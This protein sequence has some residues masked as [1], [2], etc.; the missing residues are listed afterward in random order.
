M[1]AII[2]AYDWAST[3]LGEPNGWPTTLRV[4]LRLVLAS[5][6]PML[7]MWGPHLICLHNDAFRNLLGK[8]YEPPILGMC[9]NQA[10]DAAWTILE[11]RIEHVLTSDGSIWDEALSLPLSRDA[12][13]VY[14]QLSLSPLHDENS[15]GHPDGLLLICSDVSKVHVAHQTLQADYVRLHELFRQAPG[16]MAASRGPEHLIEMAN[17]AYRALVGAE[18]ELV[19]LRVRDAMPELANQGYFE[20]LDEVFRSGKIYVGEAR[21]ILLRRTP[22]SPL[23]QRYINFIYTPI[24]AADGNVDGI[25][26]EGH[27]VTALKNAEIE[28]RTALEANAAILAH[29]RDL[30]CVLDSKGFIRQVGES[31]KAVL[32]KPPE[33][34]LDQH[35]SEFFDPNDVARAELSLADVFAGNSVSA[36]EGRSQHID[37]HWVPILWSA[38]R[39]PDQ[40]RLIAIGRDLS[41]RLKHESALRRA[42]DVELIGRLAGNVAHDFNNLLTVI[43]G[44]SEILVQELA[45]NEELGELAKNT[46]EAAE[47]GAELTRQ[48]LALGRQQDLQPRAI[49]VLQCL[50]DA[51]SFL[52]RVLP[53]TITLIIQSDGAESTAWADPDHLE[54]AVLNLCVNA[55]DAMPNG[56]RVN[57]LVSRVQLLPDE[58]CESVKLSAGHYVCLIVSDTGPGMDAST[59]ARAFEP[60]FSTKHGSGGS[61][62]GLAIVQGFAEQSGGY[63]TLDTSPGRGTT[64]TLYLPAAAT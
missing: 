33:T 48:L 35:Y 12:P 13:P 61:G 21:P 56:G 22:E 30:I 64:V 62:L 39:I 52:S 37:G 20:L 24:L 5:Q 3:P 32:G 9:A 46:C 34:F 23:E 45:V 17:D 49:N 38:S 11:P 41:E 40:D 16:F 50:H 42:R 28:L 36:F 7:I 1:E 29:S 6:H 53:A 8:H 51:R 14:C 27:D 2:G 55:R 10:L 57:I 15:S 18:R 31:T 26:T 54:R 44:N 63:A 25:L 47:R 58:I 43:L 60:F 19:G 59:A 4:T